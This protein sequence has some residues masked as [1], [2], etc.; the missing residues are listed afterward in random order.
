MAVGAGLANQQAPVE[1][2]A[3]E[4]SRVRSY[5]FEIEAKEVLHID[6]VDNTWARD[7]A[8]VLENVLVE[9]PATAHL[10]ISN[11]H[12]GLKLSR[13]WKVEIWR[14]GA[15]IIK[16]AD[17]A[18]VADDKFLLLCMNKDGLYEVVAKAELITWNG[19]EEY[20]APIDVYRNV[21]QA[22]KR[23]FERASWL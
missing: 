12:V 10:V 21:R 6:R 15:V 22:L 11:E 13:S 2:T 3:G 7:I 14:D 17:C 23:V 9:T 1:I 18:L 8:R 16:A 4:V 20:F 19:T 5:M